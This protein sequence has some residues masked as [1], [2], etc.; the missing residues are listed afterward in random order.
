[1]DGITLLTLLRSAACAVSMQLRRGY[2]NTDRTRLISRLSPRTTAGPW[3]TGR[4]WC[5]V[6]SCVLQASTCAADCDEAISRDY[7]AGVAVA[8]SL[9]APNPIPTRCHTCPLRIA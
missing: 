8:E 3:R 7:R 2:R 4:L 5:L 9:C 6:K 1:M